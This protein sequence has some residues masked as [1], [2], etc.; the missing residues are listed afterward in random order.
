MVDDVMDNVDVYL[1]Y[2][3]L[4]LVADSVVDDVIDNESVYLL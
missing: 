2:E 1:L 3:F 4:C